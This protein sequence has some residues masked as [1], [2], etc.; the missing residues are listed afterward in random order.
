MIA[1]CSVS[2]PGSVQNI[3]RHVGRS[4][5]RRMLVWKFHFN[6]SMLKHPKPHLPTPS[7]SDRS[8][9]RMRYVSRL[10]CGLLP[11]LFVSNGVAADWPRFRGPS[12]DGHVVSGR[13]PVRWSEKQ[14]V[15]WKTPVPGKGHSSPIIAGGQVWLTT[16]ITTPLSEQELEAKL[17]QVENPRGLELAASISLR[18]L[19]FDQES[20]RLLHDIE[21]FRP[22]DPEPIHSTNTYASPTPVLHAGRLYVHFGSYG[23]A[24]I[25]TQSGK[26]LWRN[27]LL[28]V[29]HQNGPG[30]SPV[31][32][33]DLLI[34]HFDGTDQQFLAALHISDGTLAWRTDRS[35]EMHP[36]GD[37]QKAYATPTI[38]ETEYGVELISPAANWVYGYNPANGKELWRAHYGE[39]G[40][41]TVPCPVV[42][43]GMAFVCTSFMKSRLLAVKIGGR[44]DVTERNVVWTSDSQIPKKP[45]LMLVG[46]E[47][48]VGNDAGI[49]TCLDVN[50]GEEIWRNRIG[51]NHSASPI[52]AGGLIY[53]FDQEG[54]ATILRAG[55]KFEK[56]A[57]NELD[58]GCNASPAAADGALYVRTA[59]HLYRIE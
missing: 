12:G 25:D 57:V 31:L 3:D 20:G 7:P 23:A 39:L 46:G 8:K 2:H 45:S 15:T 27:T 5:G 52:F 50:T 16:A 34:T 28:K 36:K 14:H 22:Q 58:S 53:Y 10:L 37:F 56:V 1:V 35:G 13:L 41:S 44:G 11:A 38:A 18:A 26:V 9:Y 32:W 51:G 59:D 40:F 42:G 29:T 54:K 6:T 48:Y 55:R 24:C 49:I 47:L 43:R 30:S 21:V 4:A 17:A 19:C 33:K